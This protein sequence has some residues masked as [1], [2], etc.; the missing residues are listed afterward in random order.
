MS[1]ISQYLSAEHYQCD[2]LFA[3]AES[4]VA[5]AR[6]EQATP[7]Y[8]EFRI[9]TEQHFRR[10]EEV[11]FPAFEQATGLVGGPTEFMRGE[12][13]Q[14]R[15][16]LSRLDHALSSRNAEQFL[17]EAETLLTLMQQHNLKEENVL[18]RLAGQALA[19][20]TDDL[21]EKM[22]ALEAQA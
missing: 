3:E 17:G 7:L 9:E 14:M 11:L 21:L 10:E 8:G 4:A 13:S 16:L 2:T 15:R 1:R 6:W 18:Y 20:E 22:Q 5:E 12:H 19:G